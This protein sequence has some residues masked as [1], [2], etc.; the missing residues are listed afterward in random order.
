MHYRPLNGKSLREMAAQRIHHANGGFANPMAT[1]QQG[2]LG[3]VLKW[4]LLSKNRFAKDL[5]DQSVTKVAIDW[6]AVKEHDGV[7]VTFIK[8]SALMI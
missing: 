1:V 2:G 5:K 7:S 4:K 8:H 6:V 3:Q